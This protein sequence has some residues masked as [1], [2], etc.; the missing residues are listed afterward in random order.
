MSKNQTTFLSYYEDIV[1]TIREPLLVLN[2]DLVI[3]SANRNFYDTFK[4][5][6]KKT[7]GRF[8]YD[9]GKQTMG[10]PQSFGRCWKKFFPK[11]TSS[12]TM[13]LIMYFRISG[14]K[15]CCSMPAVSLLTKSVL[16]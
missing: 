16:I 4:A 3:I 10:Y 7:I 14:I 6:P 2:L 1:E 5:I 9:L 8:I 12:I 15:S 13:K 11:K